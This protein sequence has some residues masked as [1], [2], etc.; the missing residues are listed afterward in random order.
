V[1]AGRLDLGS[2]ARVHIYRDWVCS[3]NGD[4][5]E[6]FFDAWSPDAKDFVDLLFQRVRE[7]EDGSLPET[8]GERMAFPGH[9]A[10]RFTRDD[11][12]A[13]LGHVSVEI[14]GVNACKGISRLLSRVHQDALDCVGA[15]GPR[16]ILP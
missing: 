12:Y 13:A 16:E 3:K 2:A 6:I 11:R 8:E 1:P 14:A 9:V 4:S 10:I 15:L 7:L 5:I